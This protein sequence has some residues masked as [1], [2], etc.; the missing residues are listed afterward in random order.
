MKHDMRIGLF[1]GTFDPPHSGHLILAEE[2]CS[3]LSLDRLL[4]VLTPEP[5]HKQG[6]VVSPLAERLEL[7]QAAIAGNPLFELSRIDLDRPGPH[8]S[9][10][11]VRIARHQNPGAEI[12]F[13]IGGDSLHDLPTWYNPEE[14]IA[15]VDYFGVMRRPSDSIDEK[16]LKQHFPGL[17]KKVCFI[18]APLL[19]ISSHQIRQRISVGKPY[20]YYLPEAVFKIISEKGYYSY[21]HDQ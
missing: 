17:F 7:T 16:Y 5:P 4:W 2:A 1:G 8:F 3:Q 20:R 19:E 15:E 12:F 18:D 21:F 9:V 13:L 11:T 14:L 6:Q 10:D